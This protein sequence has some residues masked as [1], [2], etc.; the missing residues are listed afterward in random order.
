M[1]AIEELGKNILSYSNEE[2]EGQR[3]QDSIK[4]NPCHSKANQ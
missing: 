2:E 4:R 1:V 3:E